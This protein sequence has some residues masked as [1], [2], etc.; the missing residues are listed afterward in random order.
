[1]T[2]FPITQQTTDIEEDSFNLQFGLLL[3]SNYPSVFY[4]RT[5]SVS[6]L[7][8]GILLT[9]VLVFTETIIRVKQEWVVK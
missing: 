9:Q 7:G 1:M 4:K 6:L 2:D 8:I 5:N 3:L